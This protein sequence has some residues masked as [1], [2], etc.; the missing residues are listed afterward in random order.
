MLTL[1]STRQHFLLDRMHTDQASRLREGDLFNAEGSLLQQ[2][3]QEGEPLHVPH[4]AKT[5]QDRP[6]AEFAAT[7]Q[8]DGL[9]SALFFPLS[10][11]KQWSAVIAFAAK[12]EAAYSEEHLE[13]LHNIAAQVSHSFEKTVVTEN[14]IVSAVSGLAKLAENRDPETGDHLVRMTRYSVLIAEALRANADYTDQVSAEFLHDIDRFAA[15]HDIGKVGIE[16]SVLLKPG[17]LDEEQRRIMERH[18]AIGGQVLRRCEDQM[19]SVGH[20]IFQVGIEIAECHHE[21]FDGSGYPNGLQGQD[22]P[23]AARI[24][25]AADVFDALTSKR[26]YKEAW[27]VDKALSVM[28]EESGKHFDPDIIQAMEQCLPDILQIYERL[29][30]V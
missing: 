11:N 26:P 8:Q 15:M 25:A 9:G 14:L 3:L 2:A 1:D 23:L 29:K 19:N 22:I 30:H 17:R 4:L 5:A 20:S 13:L 27:P 21:K 7:L 28:R 24:V 6:A 16:D 18:P 10:N 12:D